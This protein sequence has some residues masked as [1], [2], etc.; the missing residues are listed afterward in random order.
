MRILYYLPSLYNSG[1]TERIIT[2]KANYLAEQEGYEVIILTSE[3]QGKAPY[4]TLSDKVSTSDLGV[5]FDSN[6]SRNKLIKLLGYPFKYYTFKRKF[7]EALYHYTPDITITTL[8]R[9]LYFIHSIGDGSAKVGE[10]HYTR[11]AYTS[12]FAKGNCFLIRLLNKYW[13]KFFIKHLKKLSKVIFLTTGEKRLWPELNNTFVIPNPLT[14]FP[15][16]ASECNERKV[17]SVG[18]YVFDKGFDMLIDAWKIVQEK[19]KDWQLYIYGSGY[20]ENL[21][22]QINSLEL[23]ASCFLEEPVMN[24]EEKYLES[25]IFALCSRHEGFGMVIA[26]AMACGVPPVSFNCPGGPKDIIQ[27]G[28]DGIL[29]EHENID[30]MAQKICYLIENRSIRDQMGKQAKINIQRFKLERI[31]E[32]WMELFASLKNDLKKL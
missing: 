13:E 20:K 15:T 22:A 2:L 18:R 17:I 4:F 6:N 1:G 28:I 7:S 10:F 32:Q 8:R 30:Q 31:M 25:S 26:E 5:R 16:T 24:I 23:N 14:F 19:H 12:S 9:E 11:S 3:Q 27:D 21:I 29:V